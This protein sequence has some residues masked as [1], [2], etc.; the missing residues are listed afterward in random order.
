MFDHFPQILPFGSILAQNAQFWPFS[1]KMTYFDQ[2][3]PINGIFEQNHSEII[4]RNF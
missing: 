3:D 1:P 4:F 2:F